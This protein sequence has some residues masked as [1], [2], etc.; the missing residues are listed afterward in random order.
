MKKVVIILMGIVLLSSCKTKR[1]TTRTHTN[2]RH[3]KD[4]SVDKIN[5]K[6]QANQTIS[7]KP[8]AINK[9]VEIVVA[10]NTVYDEQFITDLYA[11]KP[12]LN[13]TKIAYIKKFSKLAINEMEAYKI[14]ASITL[15]QGLLESRYGQSELTKKSKN[16]FGIK[17]HKWTGKR[18][19]H[20]DDAKGECFR[21][22]DYDANSYRDHSLFLANKKRYAKLFSYAPNDYKS[23]AR[24]LRKAGYATDKRYPQKLIDLIEEY[25]LYIFD[26]FVLGSDYKPV[27]AIPEEV[28]QKNTYHIVQVGETLYS[29]SG[30]YYVSVNDIKR[31]NN[32]VSNNIVVGQKLKLFG[33]KEDKQVQLKQHIVKKG[34]TLYNLS[35]KYKLTVE[36]IKTLNSL[37]GNE[38]SIGQILIIE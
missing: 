18:V 31:F 4:R 1:A 27:V 36:K 6:P 3:I 15:A 14:P 7:K 22:Y 10:P 11:T 28:K 12:S 30:K 32:L 23:W 33:V 13:Q 16:H 26:K 5:K 29:I 2:T 34:D 17:C 21:K 38:L 20:D 35:R 9:S 8:E 24:G 25:E 37:E 19:Y